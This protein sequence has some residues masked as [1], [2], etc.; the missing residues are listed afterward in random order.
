MVIKFYIA[1]VLAST[2]FLGGCGGGT[3]NIKDILQSGLAGVTGT[4]NKPS[5]GTGNSML[6][7]AG[8][9]KPI[10]S[11]GTSTTVSDCISRMPPSLSSLLQNCRQ[12]IELQKKGYLSPY[13]ASSLQKLQKFEREYVQKNNLPKLT[14]KKATVTQTKKRATRDIAGVPPAM[15]GMMRNFIAG[16]NEF[17]DPDL[18]KRM[19]DVYA[20]KSSN[21]PGGSSSSSSKCQTKVYST[22]VGGKYQQGRK[23]TC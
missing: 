4:V 16:K 21:G 2:F 1:A 10:T 6:D 18:A 20:S 23:T 17:N 3:T 8:Y 15:Q 9:T 7:A 19:S 12:K 11:A 13:E 22:T 14:Q 5:R